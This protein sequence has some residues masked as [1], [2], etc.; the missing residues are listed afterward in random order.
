[1]MDVL[2]CEQHFVHAVI[3]SGSGYETVKQL[4]AKNAKV[5]LASRYPQKA[6]EVIRKFEQE[7]GRGNDPNVHFLHLEL[8]DMDAIK[9]SARS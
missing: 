1:M 7:P 6:A 3:S 4:V 9:K 8:T 5:Y 2:N